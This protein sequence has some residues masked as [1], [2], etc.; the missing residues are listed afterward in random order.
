MI[1]EQRIEKKSS[2]STLFFRNWT[3]VSNDTIQNVKVTKLHDGES[4]IYISNTKYYTPWWLQANGFPPDEENLPKD[5]AC[6]K[7]RCTKV[8]NATEQC[9]SK[10]TE[11]SIS[12]EIVLSDLSVSMN[13][14]DLNEAPYLTSLLNKTYSVNTCEDSINPI[15][16]GAFYEPTLPDLFGESMLI[17]SE[18]VK[19]VRHEISDTGSTDLYS[20]ESALSATTETIIDA[21][22]LLEKTFTINIHAESTSVNKCIDKFAE[23][24]CTSSESYLCD[25]RKIKDY[26]DCVLKEEEALLEKNS[27]KEKLNELFED[28]VIKSAFEENNLIS[29]GM[30]NKRYANFFKRLSINS[31]NISE[32]AIQAR[33]KYNKAARAYNVT[34]K[35][36]KK[37]DITSELQLA[38]KNIMVPRNPQPPI[39]MANIYFTAQDLRDSDEYKNVLKSMDK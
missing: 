23:D 38:L 34:H 24:L 21:S 11:K 30:V 13:N 3:F 1:Q 8:K 14:L 18:T 28:A 32:S 6:A 12:Q 39:P 27:E 19:N 10:I 35:K 17:N 36:Y 7:K 9:N 22:V 16:L 31:K 15:G 20:S 33:E 37:V 5:E 29:K 26:V 2:Y 4:Y 25:L